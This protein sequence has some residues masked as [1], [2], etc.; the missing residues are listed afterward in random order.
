MLRLQDRAENNFKENTYASFKIQYMNVIF[1]FEY[2]AAYLNTWIDC[3]CRK[4]GSDLLWVVLIISLRKCNF[5][6]NLL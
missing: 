3:K 4:M 6:A 5:R 2:A 1:F